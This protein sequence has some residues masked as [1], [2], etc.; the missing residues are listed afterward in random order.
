MEG[1]EIGE[2]QA[3]RSWQRFKHSLATRQQINKLVKQQT[4]S[5]RDALANHFRY[6][7]EHK[8]MAK[9]ALQILR[10]FQEYTENEGVPLILSECQTPSS[11][12]P[13]TFW[14]TKTANHRSN[15]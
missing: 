8:G 2:L 6:L 13:T 14:S 10:V 1:Q 7:L 12:N 4:F 9:S 5:E 3:P 15:L 11:V